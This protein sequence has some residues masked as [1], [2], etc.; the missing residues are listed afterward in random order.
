METNQKTIRMPAALADKWLE[1]LRGGKYR[2]TTG[3]LRR[4]RCAGPDAPEGFCCLGVLQMVAD[5][6]V[7]RSFD[8]K[9]SSLP[10]FKWQDDH[11]VI[12]YHDD[13]V[14]DGCS[15]SPYL[16]LLECSASRANDSGLYDFSKIADAIEAA[17][18]RT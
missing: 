8:G 16:P 11:G 6:D 17:L 3:T 12:F 1:A 14:V 13:L 4:E 15:P 18:E 9:P 2:Q 7:E 5:G 10:S